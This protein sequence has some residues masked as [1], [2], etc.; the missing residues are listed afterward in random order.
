MNEHDRLV[1][2]IRELETNR[3]VLLQ[4]RYL[5]DE[6][7]DV[8]RFKKFDKQIK[9]IQKEIDKANKKLTKLTL[10]EGD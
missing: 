8:K 5:A 6:A 4:E 3:Q 2:K 9:K 1:Q 10:E 7:K